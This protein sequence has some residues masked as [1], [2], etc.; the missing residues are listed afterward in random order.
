MPN[1]EKI[2]QDKNILQWVT[3]YKISFSKF[4]VQKQA[5][6]QNF[7]QKFLKSI[8]ELKKLGAIKKSN[9]CKHQYVSSYFIRKKPN[10]KQRF[11]L[12]LKGLNTFINCPHFKLE[13]FRSVKNIIS[14]DCY[15]ANIDLKDAYFLL[16][17]HQRY[18]KF[19]KFKY[20]NQLY[21][22]TCMPFGLSI[23]PFIFTKI[24]KPIMNHLRSLGFLSVLYLDDI[25][26]FGKNKQDCYNNVNYTINLLT[27]LGFLINN[28]KS[29][30]EPTQEIKFLGFMFNS[31]NMTISIPPEKSEKIL[32]TIKSTKNKKTMRIR[33]F[34]RFIGTLVSICPA[35]PYGWAH[36]KNFEHCK[37]K[38]LK[39]CSGNYDHTLKI[40][41]DLH[42]DFSWWIANLPSSELSLVETPYVLTIFT[43]ASN[44]GWGASCKNKSTWGFWNS[45]EKQYHINYLELLAAFNGI[46]SFA[47]NHSNCNII[48]RIDNITAISYIN[49]MGGIRFPHLND[50]TQQIWKWCES[51]K[52]IIFASYVN[53]RENVIADW[54]SRQKPTESEYS[55]SQTAFQKIT[56][57]F[58]IPQIDLFASYQNKKC[59]IFVS[60]HPDPQSSFIDAFTLNW[61][62]F[63][64]YAFPPFSLLPRVLKKIKAEK[65]K[66]IVVYPLWKTQPW[67]PVLENLQITKPINFYSDKSLLLSPYR[68]PHPLWKSLILGASVLSG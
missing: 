15:M 44:S 27:S 43:D 30:F 4:P 20:N 52:I 21:E 10:G 3:G 34:A 1:W 37:Y 63:F 14:K 47:K 67:F 64:F 9:P 12:N 31:S 17:I 35:V 68:Q 6:K 61:G 49:R 57:I 28:E 59:Q 22:F 38:A 46:K 41:K 60:W 40:N 7:S 56:N 50:I 19:L 2:T 42:D 58:G 33:D 13:D 18:R 8:T 65:A 54:A 66:G 36:I 24:F 53:T 16:P 23:A 48:L 32:N 5:P 11:I 26:L 25:L 62:N 39:Q 51:R 45:S 29:L 55:L